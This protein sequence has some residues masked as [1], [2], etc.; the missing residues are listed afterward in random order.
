MQFIPLILFPI[1]W[2][3][4][5]KYFSKTKGKLISHFL[6]FILGF[7]ALFISTA[8]IMPAPTAEQIQQ[9]ELAKVEEQKTKELQEQNKKVEELAKKEKE[10]LAKSEQQK[11]KELQEQNKKLEELA[12]KEKEE[13]EDIEDDM[14]ITLSKASRLDL[15]KLKKLSYTYAKANKVDEKY[16]EKVYDCIGQRVWEKNKELLLLEIAGWCIK[17]TTFAHY[18]KS[19]KYINKAEFM[20]FVSPWD[21][22][23]EPFNNYI[24]SYINNPKSFEHVKTIT[25]YVTDV[26]K[27]YVY[28]VT[29]FRGT[30]S[31]GA[32]VT[33]TVKAKVD[34]KTQHIYDIE[35]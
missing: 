12:K 33:N 3:V 19:I 17:E 22:S 11:A 2:I 24:K 14:K 27:P 23:Y 15:Q 1:I 5:Y 35:Q 7:I 32:I 6:G 30:N 21:M 18:D 13:L 26:E 20:P 10:E 34:A 25:R 29:T 9:R 4:A 16:H 31:F 28:L 8:I